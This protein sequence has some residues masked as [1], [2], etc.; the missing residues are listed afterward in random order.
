M[1]LLKRYILWFYLGFDFKHF[2]SI[3]CINF[4]CCFNCFSWQ[5]FQVHFFWKASIWKLSWSALTFYQTFH[6]FNWRSY[7][8]AFFTS[9]LHPST[10]FSPIK[11][12]P[13]K[14]QTSFSKVSSKYPSD[15]CRPIQNPN[16]TPNYEFLFK[17]LFQ[18]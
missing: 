17:I 8:F 18:K 15:P 4:R 13:I 9:F 16:F 3:I 5:T 2:R 12:F 7:R 10:S 14:T 11:G 1:I 6:F